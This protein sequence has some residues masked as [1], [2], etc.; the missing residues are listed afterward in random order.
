M[1]NPDQNCYSASMKDSTK[2][3]TYSL[4]FTPFTLSLTFITSN[5][6]SFCT[7]LLLA[8]FR[9]WLFWHSQE[10]QPFQEDGQFLKP[11]QKRP[12]AIQKKIEIR[13][14]NYR[15]E[16]KKNEFWRHRSGLFGLLAFCSLVVWLDEKLIF[17]T[18]FLTLMT[19]WMWFQWWLAW[20][21]GK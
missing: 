12:P 7:G 14:E 16:T 19:C 5:Y 17:Y 9:V 3:L 20:R 18:F 8:S 6:I 11:P 2:L 21:V 10:G 13:Y 15:Q 4:L 1:T